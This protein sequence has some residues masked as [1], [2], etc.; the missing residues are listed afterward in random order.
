MIE[1]LAPAG[2]RKKMNTAFHFGADAVYVGGKNFSLRAFSDNF[3]LDG[4]KDAVTY[5]HSVGK[6][7]YVAVN[8]FPK[9][10]DF[11]EIEEF[12]QFLEEI[13]ADGV[14]VS[15]IGVLEIASKYKTPVH[16]STQ[17]N[18]TNGYAARVYKELGASRII[19]AREVSLDDIKE[20]KD[21]SGADIEVFVHGA[22]CI[23]YSGRCLLS[24]Y[25]AD[26]DSNRGECVQSCRWEYLI[27]EKNREKELT[28]VEDERGTYILN[29][30]D[31]N[32]IEHLRELKDA[33]VDSIKIEGRMKTQ[34]Y[35][36]N[37]VNAY[38]RA[39]DNN[40][41][42][43]EELTE[44]LL[45][46]SHRGYTTGFYLDETDRQDRY[47]SQSEGTR[48]FVGEVIENYEEGIVIEQRNRFKTG[49]TLE[50]L[51][52]GENFNKTIFIDRMYDIYGNIIDD[53]KLVQQVIRIPT[54]YR[55]NKF[56]ILRK[57]I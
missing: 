25:L 36:G 15:D 46:N 47:T 11:K 52:N 28:M 12:L 51:S 23:S 49:D 54:E 8:I 45:K 33:G 3:D 5:A 56:D 26:R 13:A 2:N 30:K 6:R 44:E 39:L 31:L 14:I 29:S 41:N 43:T 17:A 40:L 9:N 1:L 37:V 7:V 42:A 50:I 21:I 34:Y 27:R 16:I 20:I 22:M 10:K 55:L 53:A 38:R 32:M 18:T 35:V 19:L 24:N 48:E 57:K 4:L